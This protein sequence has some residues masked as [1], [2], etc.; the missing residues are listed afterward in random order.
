MPSPRDDGF[1]HRANDTPVF[2]FSN[3]F[4]SGTPES[5]RQ[6]ILTP[7]ANNFCIKYMITGTWPDIQYIEWLA[8]SSRGASPD[9]A[10]K[11][12]D[13]LNIRGDHAG[14]PQTDEPSE[15]KWLSRRDDGATGQHLICI[16][17]QSW[18]QNTRDLPDR[19]G[20]QTRNGAGE[21][22][23]DAPYGRPG[24][25][26]S[27]KIK[28][29]RQEE[30]LREGTSTS[31]LFTV[32][33]NPDQE[34]VK[35]KWSQE[36]VSQF[37][38]AQNRG[39]ETSV[40]TA[41][42]N[43]Y[44]GGGIAT[45]TATPPTPPYPPSDLFPEPFALPSFSSPSFPSP[46]PTVDTGPNQTDDDSADASSISTGAIAGIA[47]GCTIAL[48]LLFTAV[49]FLVARHR[50]RRRHRPPQQ[51][52]PSNDKA[53]AALMD[54]RR[55][56]TTHVAQ[57]V[58]SPQSPHSPQSPN[59]GHLSPVVPI[60]PRQQNEE[61]PRAA[62][63]SFAERGMTPEERRRWEEEERQLDDEIARKNNSL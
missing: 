41:I 53:T 54:E 46:S 60:R 2:D 15:R 9:H 50:R 40:P 38:S 18:L 26:M 24:D 10:E 55:I 49:W 16:Q 23:S 62:T 59:S 27:L 25:Y 34:P 33:E 56:S 48:I 61:S 42:Y 32:A 7:Q 3:T 21:V 13:I 57:S 8:S 47:A 35:G 12:I 37:D 63:A 29:S 39:T 5:W 20:R 1:G 43:P 19:V 51:E 11:Q 45:S 17:I 6:R 44:G 30:V 58:Q 28:W 31:G 4:G 22:G 52:S 14:G 36:I